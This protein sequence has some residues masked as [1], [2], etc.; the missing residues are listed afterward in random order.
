MTPKLTSYANALIDHYPDVKSL[1]PQDE[2]DQLFEQL[3]PI[4]LSKHPESLANRPLLFWHGTSDV[5]IPV[6]HSE[7][8]YYEVC[9]KY[10]DKNKLQLLLEEN[11]GH[12][13]S[14]YAILETVKWFV[15][16]L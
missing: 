14:R 2:L 12:K 3:E 13:V 16:H 10:Q 4:D 7:T 11:Q 6:D 8:F 1:P 5:V 15:N 9:H